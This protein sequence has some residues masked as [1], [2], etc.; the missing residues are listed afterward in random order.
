MIEPILKKLGNLL[1]TYIGIM[2]IIKGTKIVY[3]KG[4][5][6]LLPII[7]KKPPLKYKI[8]K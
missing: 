5:A 7:T 6:L 3:L 2:L 1:M 4:K 8:K